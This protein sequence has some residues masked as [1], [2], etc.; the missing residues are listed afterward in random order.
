[1]LSIKVG[2]VTIEHR[3]ELIATEGIFRGLAKQNMLFHQCLGELIDNAIAA[4]R[5]DQKFKVDVIFI[6][7]SAEDTVDVY[8]ADNSKG[9]SLE[10]LK[11]ALQLGESATT[12][13]RLNEH[14]FG[15]KNALATLSGENGYWKIWTKPIGGRIICSAEGPFKQNMR[16]VEGD[17]FPNER[18]L[19]TDISTLIKVH[20]KMSFVQSVQGRGAP[21][22][23]MATLRMWLIEHLGV[24]T[25]DI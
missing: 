20:V 16:I 15:L 12:E 6:K 10:I 4:K 23:D 13:S 19:P 8:V 5:D 3:I 21:T 18:F 11:K 1:L 2:I 24:F 17:S 25:E 9:M 7:N 14:G 22:T